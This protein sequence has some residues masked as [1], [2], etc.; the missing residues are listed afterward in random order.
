MAVRVRIACGG[1]AA[2]L[3]VEAAVM[4]GLEIVEARPFNCVVADAASLVDVLRAEEAEAVVVAVVP[5]GGCLEAV[6]TG[7][8]LAVPQDRRKGGEAGNV[9]AL[10]AALLSLTRDAGDA[11]ADGHREHMATVGE[12]ASCVAHE[13][14]NPLAGL[15]A[16]AELL[17]MQLPEGDAK[18]RTAH[19][20][21]EQTD[22]LNR[23]L[24][25]VLAF[26][27]PERLELSPTA[28]DVLLEWL[29]IPLLPQ[30]ETAGVDVEFSSSTGPA[31]V[32]VDAEAVERVFLNIGL[33]AVAAMPEG[34]VLRVTAENVPEGIAFRFDDTGEGITEEDLTRVFEPFFSRR[35]GG[36]GLGLAIA[37][38]I[39]RQHEGSI[40]IE[41]KRGEGTSVCV[42]FPAAGVVGS[43]TD[44]AGRINR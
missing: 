41:S 31:R 13:I 14:R 30:A 38:R 5:P 4:A 32:M 37:A 15:R 35:P 26:A 6:R 17:E 1:P 20:L 42:V 8:R 7:A 43:V 29:R 22:R 23:V 44:E 24:D 39:V 11:E 28:P 18:K 9:D 16:N 33:N 21:V 12:L 2:D 34:G 27:R 40:N 10:A 25:D 3:A 19:L 36:T